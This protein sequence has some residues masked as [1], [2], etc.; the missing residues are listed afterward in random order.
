MSEQAETKRITFIR[1][2]SGPG[3]IHRQG[4]TKEL[5][6]RTADRFIELGVAE[7]AEEQQPE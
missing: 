6:V 4:E 5:P 1:T 2:I 3:W 7:L